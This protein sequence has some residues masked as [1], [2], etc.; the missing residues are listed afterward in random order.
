MEQKANASGKEEKAEASRLMTKFHDSHVGHTQKLTAKLE[1]LTGYES[2]LTILGHVQ[3]GGTPSPVD[4]VLAT[5]LGAACARYLA[6]GGHGDMM[7][8]RGSEVVPVPLEE[9]AGQKKLVPPDHPLVEAAKLVG[10]C[11]GD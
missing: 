4:R 8:I 6:D 3:R 5:Q 7:A 9:V 2:R 1:K 10:T 11:F